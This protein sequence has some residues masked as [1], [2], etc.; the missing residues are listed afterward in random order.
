MESFLNSDRK[1]IFTNNWKTVTWKFNLHVSHNDKWLDAA[2]GKGE[3][4]CSFKK[5]EKK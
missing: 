2:E 3:V 4:P 5:K 1:V